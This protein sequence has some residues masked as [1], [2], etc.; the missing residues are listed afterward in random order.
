MRLL[1]IGISLFSLVT[2]A[3]GWEHLGHEWHAPF[4]SDSQYKHR[5]LILNNPNLAQ[6][7]PHAQVSTP[8]QITA[9]FLAREET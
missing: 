1:K 7:D 3:Y 8:W 4:P 9:I 2:N 5:S 6:V